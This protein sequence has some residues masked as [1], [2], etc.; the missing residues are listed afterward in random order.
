[1]EIRRRDITEVRLSSTINYAKKDKAVNVS[2]RKVLL[3]Y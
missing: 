1:M 3:L 2:K